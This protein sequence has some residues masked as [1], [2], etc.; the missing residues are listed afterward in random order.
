[1]CHQYREIASYFRNK[2]NKHCEFIQD[3]VTMFLKID[4]YLYKL[5]I[6]KQNN[7]DY[8]S[9]KYKIEKFEEYI[10]CLRKESF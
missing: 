9:S 6:E 8:L 4:S 3:N 10:L 7:K 2:T 5:P 1:M